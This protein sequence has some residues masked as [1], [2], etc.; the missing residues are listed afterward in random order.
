MD[1]CFWVCNCRYQ[2]L[3]S[4]VCDYLV[5]F[6]F[7][8]L[9]CFVLLLE[10]ESLIV[11]LIIVMDVIT[12]TNESKTDEIQWTLLHLILMILN[13]WSEHLLFMKDDELKIVS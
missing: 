6:V 9:Y 3:R 12:S 1:K 5:S 10:Y 4:I 11:I 7:L 2:A 13:V 8:F